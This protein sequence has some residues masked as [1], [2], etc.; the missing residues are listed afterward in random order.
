MS[1]RL[2]KPSKIILQHFNKLFMNAYQH[3]TVIPQA[4][5]GKVVWVICKLPIET[6]RDLITE[7]WLQSSPLVK[8]EVILMSEKITDY[9]IIIGK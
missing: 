9:L 1:K 4:F 8:R 5:D 2:A 7:F 3:L 6:S